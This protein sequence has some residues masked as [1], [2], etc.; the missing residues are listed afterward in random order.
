[1]YINNNNNITIIFKAPGAAGSTRR[2]G[3]CWAA[4]AAGALYI[5]I[6]IHTYLFI[7]ITIH[8]IL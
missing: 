1:M 7:Y 5:Y 3:G 2:P 8:I 6:Y 4:G